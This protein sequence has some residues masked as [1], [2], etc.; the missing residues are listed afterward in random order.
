MGTCWRKGSPIRVKICL[1]KSYRG[2]LLNLSF[3]SDQAEDT[4]QVLARS[5]Q[6]SGKSVVDL[7]DH[8]CNVSILA[9]S[10]Q[11]IPFNPVTP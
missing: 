5:Y 6:L 1:T 4:F 2:K 3:P 10:H 9:W 11:I 7:C 8:N